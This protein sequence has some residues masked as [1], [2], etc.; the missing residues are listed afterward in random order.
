MSIEII[1]L[2][3]ERITNLFAKA[4]NLKIKVFFGK[5]GDENFI[6]KDTRRGFC[7]PNKVLGRYEIYIRLDRNSRALIFRTLAHEL[8]HAWKRELE[9]EK[10]KKSHDP[11]FWKI[12]DEETFPFVEEKLSEVDRTN[13]LKLLNPTT[14]FDEIMDEVYLDNK[15]RRIIFSIEKENINRAW[16]LVRGEAIKGNLSAKVAVSTA[17]K[18]KDEYK[19]VIYA[20]EREDISFL[21]MKLQNLG[22]NYEFKTD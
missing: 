14:N 12:M 11:L 18:N 9:K 20:R 22:M 6:A 3:V 19:I 16:K 13:L 1:E 8:A 2:E 4:R 17:R 15:E 5:L 21:V 7:S 10:F